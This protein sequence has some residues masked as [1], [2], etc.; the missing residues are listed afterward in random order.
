MTAVTNSGPLVAL[1]KLNHL[2]LLPNLYERVLVPQAVH[3]ECVLVG[4]ERGYE[5]YARAIAE[6]MGIDTVGTIGILVEAYQRDHLVDDVLDEL[7]TAIE[8][9]EDIWIHPALCH[10]V[11][12]EI[13]QR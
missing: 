4:R 7:L 5:V 12:R 1:A 11:R 9:R 8:R 3:R 6:R 13:L 10:R 2:H